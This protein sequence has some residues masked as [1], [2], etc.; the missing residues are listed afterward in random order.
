MIFFLFVFFPWK[1]SLF[2]EYLTVSWYF[3]ALTGLS[4]CSTSNVST[5]CKSGSRSLLLFFFFFSFSRP[6]NFPVTQ[7]YL[8]SWTATWE[9]DRELMLIRAVGR[10]LAGPGGAWE[11]TG[12][13][14]NTVTENLLWQAQTWRE[15]NVNLYLKWLCDLSNVKRGYHL[16]GDELWVAIASCW[17]ALQSLIL[18]L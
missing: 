14:G 8:I 12:D 13:P 18:F 6:L 3:S 5:G 4:V 7:S 2:S 15:W 9:E 1:F 16:R 10:Q 11:T 17:Q